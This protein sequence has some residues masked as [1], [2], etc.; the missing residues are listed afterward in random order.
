M[1]PADGSPSLLAGLRIDSSG[2]YPGCW[3]YL[4]GGGVEPDAEGRVDVVATIRREVEEEIGRCGIEVDPV[5]LAILE[6]RSVGTWEIVHRVMITQAPDAPPGWEHT[7][8]ACI[9]PRTLPAP[10]SAAATLMATL[11]DDVLR[12]ANPPAG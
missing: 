4:P 10:A 3:E 6:D 5:A 1:R 9:T 11:A 8:V 12:A 7:R 2:S